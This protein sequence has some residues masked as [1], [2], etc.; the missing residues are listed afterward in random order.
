MLKIL[1]IAAFVAGSAAAQASDKTDLQALVAKAVVAA[2]PAEMV[3]MC[4]DDAI[5]LDDFAPHIWQG[6]KACEKWL[7]DYN[8]FTEKAGLKDGKVAI[9]KA[10]HFQIDGATAYAV[11]PASVSYTAKDGKAISHGGATWSFAFRKTG[12]AWKISGWAW[13][14]GAN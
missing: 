5:V 1:I 11:Y 2:T 14:D 6:G 8:A 10:R 7:T 4:T 13:A 9:G 12:K 3:A